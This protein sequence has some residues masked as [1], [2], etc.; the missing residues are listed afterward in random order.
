M[1]LAGLPPKDAM[2]WLIADELRPPPAA[3]LAL[4]A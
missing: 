1:L 2:L 3:V 4:S